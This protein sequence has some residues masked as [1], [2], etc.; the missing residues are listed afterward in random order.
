MTEL[1]QWFESLKGSN[2]VVEQIAQYIYD[3]MMWY[4][5]L[6]FNQR[7]VLLV[8]VALVLLLLTV[9]IVTLSRSFLLSRRWY[10]RKSIPKKVNL[11]LDRDRKW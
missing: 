11:H 1:Q 3:V 2:D 10:R 7:L 4:Q 8:G 9:I 6:S 5:Y